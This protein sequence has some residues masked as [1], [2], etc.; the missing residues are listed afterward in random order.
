MGIIELNEVILVNQQDEVI[1]KMEKL[2]AHQKG[3]LHRAFSIFIFNTKNELLLL[4][5]ANGKYHSESLWTNTC[6]SHPSPGES[7]ISAANRRLFE[8][9]GMSC[10]LKSA[11]S[12]IYNVELDNGLYEHELDHVVIGIGNLNPVINPTEASMFCWKSIDEIIKDINSSPMN[13]TSWFKIIM[14]DHLEKL[15][16]VLNITNESL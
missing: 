8:E 1:G 5:R 3:L 9:M 12:F 16:N 2:E 11:F 7:I 14:K 6:C 10:E 4:K 15:I 13:Y